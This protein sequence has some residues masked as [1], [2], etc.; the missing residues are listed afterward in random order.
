M[1]RLPSKV[2]I[3]YS[4]AIEIDEEGRAFAQR[5]IEAHGH[6]E[7]M[8]TGNLLETLWRGSFIPAMATLVRRECYEKVGLFDENLFF[9]VWDLWLRLASSFEFAYSNR[10]SAKYRV[11][12]NS[13]VRAW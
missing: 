4:N 3:V 12:S 8:P 10:I 6:F 13:M 7:P 11:V 9:E 5:F 1:E 2:G